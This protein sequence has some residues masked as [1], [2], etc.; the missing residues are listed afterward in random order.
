[1]ANLTE[2]EID[3]IAQ[4]IVAADFSGRVAVWTVADGK[5]AGE[6]N[7]NPHAALLFHM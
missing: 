2:Q 4:R 1:M 3:L 5:P 6:L 7:A